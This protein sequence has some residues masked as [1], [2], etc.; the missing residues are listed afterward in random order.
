[1]ILEVGGRGSGA[2]RNVL[3][4]N[5]GDGQKPY[6][7]LAP[8]KKKNIYA[9]VDR[10]IMYRYRVCFQCRVEQNSNLLMAFASIVI[11]GVGRLETHDHIFVRSKTKHL[12]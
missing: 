11:L 4:R 3:L 7:V 6:G 10:Y 1:M 5:R 9:S 2:W 8:V 12:I